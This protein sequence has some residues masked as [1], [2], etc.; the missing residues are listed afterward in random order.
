LCLLQK[1]VFKVVRLLPESVIDLNEDLLVTLEAAS[2][3]RLMEAINRQRLV[4]I[5]N[6]VTN[7]DFVNGLTFVVNDQQL[8]HTVV[9]VAD[10]HQLP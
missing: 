5:I 3:Q 9:L 10:S 7:K 4:V 1:V 8:K 2:C 6:E